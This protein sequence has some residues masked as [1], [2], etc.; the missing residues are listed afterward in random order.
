MTG[1]SKASGFSLI[2]QGTLRALAVSEL[3][4]P[5]YKGLGFN[6]LILAGHRSALL[7]LGG[8][9]FLG[10]SSVRSQSDSS[11]LRA[12]LEGES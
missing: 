3:S 4:P 8:H 12:V 11:N 10:M 7:G 6:I 1:E 5:Q 2:T 9:K